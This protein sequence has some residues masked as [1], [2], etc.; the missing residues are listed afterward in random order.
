MTNRKLSYIVKDQSPLIMLDT[1]AVG[2]ACAAMWKRR[3]GTVLVA[4]ASRRLVGIFTGRDAVQALAR[5]DAPA[6]VRLSKAMTRKPVT[7]AADARAIDALQAMSAGG[8]RHVPVVAGASILGVVS[9]GDFKGM[10]FEHLRWCDH[11][12]VSAPNRRLGD[13]VARQQPLAHAASD[14]VRQACQSMSRRKAGSVLVLE[15]SGK[16]CGIFTGRDAVRLLG[17]A[18]DPAATPLRKAMTR[19][20]VTIGQDS[21]AIDALRTMSEHGFRH[22][23]VV[24]NG[25]VL[26]VVS[27]SDFT[28][29]EIDRLDEEEH[30]AECIW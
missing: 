11:G 3:A 17:A 21:F 12:C 6:A 30:L 1:D 29:C 10:E 18:E 27:R 2:Q 25:K 7:I 24:Q 20:P 4:D 9:R 13:I 5:N 16:L 26:G 15:N 22:L 19:E 23:P 8:F 28:G 14:T